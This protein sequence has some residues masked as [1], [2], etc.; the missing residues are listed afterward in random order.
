MTFWFTSDTHFS[1]E[2]ILNLGDGRPF[3]DIGQHNEVLL[4]NINAVVHSDDTL[5]HLGDVALGPFNPEPVGLSYVK[6][7]ICRTVLIPGNHDRIS[8]V[9]KPAYRAKWLPV[10]EDAFDVI[11]DEVSSF[12]LNDIH[13]NLSHYPYNGDSQKD[14][15]RH[16]D[17]RAVDY[18]TPI[19]HGHNHCGPEIRESFS[20]KGTP[21]FAVGVDA[22]NWAPVHEDV[23][24]EW[25][26]RVS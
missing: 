26:E 22:N 10:Y 13:F 1:H 12:A 3:K 25:L 23:I 20:A 7:I 9:C 4:A 14:I 24:A 6:R 18:G 5:I 8:S 19:V 15:E 2:N 16:A 11:W 21:Q 17:I